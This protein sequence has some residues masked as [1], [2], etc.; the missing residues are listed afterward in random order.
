[1]HEFLVEMTTTIPE[2]TH[3]SSP[4]PAPATVT[5][6]M[7]P[8]L[9]TVERTA[10]VAAAAYL[11][12]HAGTTALVVMDEQA[13]RPPASSPMPTSPTRWPTARMPTR[14]GSTR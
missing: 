11:M 13:D 14:S 6:V 10:H 5:D 2:G 4:P 9:T 3:D 1:M 8:P 7:R 12:K